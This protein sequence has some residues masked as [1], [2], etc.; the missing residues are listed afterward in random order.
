MTVLNVKTSKFLEYCQLRTHPKLF[1]I[2]NE[3]YSNEMGCVYWGVGTDPNGAGQCVKRTDTLHIIDYDI[4]SL[5]RWQEITYTKVVCIVRPQKANPNHTHI[6]IGDKHIC[7]PG[8][9]GTN[10]ASF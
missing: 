9:V 4:I 7:Y 6:K 3:S 2:W 1:N 10:T 8:N 5:E